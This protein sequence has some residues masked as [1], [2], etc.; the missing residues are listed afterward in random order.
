MKF[1]AIKNMKSIKSIIFTF[2]NLKLAASLAFGLCVA[3]GVFG[4]QLIQS[5]EVSPNPLVAGRTFSISVKASPDV[6]QANARVAFRSADPRTL[7]IQLTKQNDVWTGSGTVPADLRRELPGTAGAM[8]TLTLIG[9]DNQRDEQVLNLGVKIESISAV[10]DGSVLTVTGDEVDNVITVSRDAAGRILVNGGAVPVT[11]GV[12]TVG[13]TSLIRV[14]GQSGNDNIQLDEANGVLPVANLLGDAGNDTLIS[15]SGDDELDGGT[16]DDSLFGR[17]GADRLLG[18]RGKD[19]LS[20]GVGDD[21]LF[22]GD[23]DDIIDWLPGD[24]SDLA[25]GEDGNDEMLFV[26]GNGSEDVDIS[27]NGPRLR[28]FR[29]PGLVTMDCDGIE[30]VR[31]EA[32]GGADHIIV[33]DLTDTKVRNVAL[34]ISSRGAGDSDSR[35]TVV[36]EG[37]ATADIINVAGAAD[38]VSVTRLNS[39][40]TVLGAEQDLDKLI[41]NS[42][43]G[44]DIVDASA[45]LAGVNLLT[46]DGGIGIDTLTGGHGNDQLIGGSGNDTV[47]GGEG[48]DTLIW[49]P[50]DANDVFEGQA[51]QDTML[52]N[53]ANVAEE[54]VLSANGPRLR[55]TRN[56]ATV[57]MDCDDIEVVHFTAK[58]E[59]DNITVNDLS[60][61][62]VREVKLDLSASGDAGA[63]DNSSD[64]IIV[65][66]TAANDAVNVN[67]SGGSVSVTGLTATVNIL[68]S[69]AADDRLIVKTLAGDDVVN[70]SGLPDGLIGLTVD[71]GE[72]DDV[73]V[74]SGGNDTLL[75]GL[76]DD[77]LSGGPGVDVLDGGPGANVIFQD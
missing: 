65:N 70:A 69:V 13:N 66:G 36:V 43:G 54:I 73:L 5:V 1:K 62:D 33:H 29:N 49:N 8:V 20:G 71:G 31:F 23:D 35:D 39:A 25:E 21:Q 68:S 6:T 47:F 27:A 41:V 3:N 19:F 56:I 16:G 74:G 63:G 11:G 42:L 46:L 61:T 67:G 15:G 28:F 72:N 38:E 7:D 76:G 60:G 58:G 14:I 12:A 10:F 9:A 26:G 4:A 57:T 48:D 34:D 17:R 75:G 77:I 64:T 50:G 55:F 53:G 32:N 52:F 22:G 45:V 24:G 51:G 30:Q 59:A 40:V 2:R 44:D 37:T 18:G